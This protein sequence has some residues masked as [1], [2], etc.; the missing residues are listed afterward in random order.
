MT[1]KTLLEVK[2]REVRSKLAAL[3]GVDELTDE[4]RTEISTLS[5]ESI[6]L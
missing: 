2:S 1:D 3:A 4:Q 6:D 5:K